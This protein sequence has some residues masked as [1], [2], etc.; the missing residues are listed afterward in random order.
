MDNTAKKLG[1]DLLK[2][3][4]LGFF[5]INLL[6]QK[7]IQPKIYVRL[8]KWILSSGKFIVIVVELIT[9]SAFVYRYKLDSDLI[10]VQE[11][12]K[13]IVPYIQSLKNNEI[14]IRQTQ[15]QLQTIQQ[16]KSTNP[17][18]ENIFTKIALLTPK[19]IRLTNISLQ[20]TSP[21]KTDLT[22]SG[23]TPSNL[24]LSTF[25]KTLQNDPTFSNIS[26]TNISFEGE[27]SFIITGNLNNKG[28]KQS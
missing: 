26:L 2:V 21:V 6:V 16:I 1:K 19:S 24:E 8:L 3:P 18:F 4:R 17:A 14:L 12:I 11:K 10:D 20:I 25:I 28:G 9:I 22:I 15:F 23:V 7:N 5:K 27:T 13:E